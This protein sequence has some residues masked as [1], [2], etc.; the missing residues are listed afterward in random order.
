M[1]V[2]IIVVNLVL[3]IVIAVAKVNVKTHVHQVA[4]MDVQNLVQDYVLL[5][6]A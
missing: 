5:L 6:V 2:K 4:L 3:N 1:Y